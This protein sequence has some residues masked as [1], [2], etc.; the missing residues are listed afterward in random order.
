MIGSFGLYE[1]DLQHNCRVSSI[2]YR[3]SSIEYRASSIEHRVSSIE[4]RVSS[5]VLVACAVQ[6]QINDGV[7]PALVFMRMDLDTSHNGVASTRIISVE[8]SSILYFYQLILLGPDINAYYRC[9]YRA[10]RAVKSMP[11]R[12]YTLSVHHA[13]H[14]APVMQSIVKFLG[15]L[16]TKLKFSCACSI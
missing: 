14:T 11:Y 6:Y 4:H 1:L 5:T 9:Y 2:E 12:V 7:D 16:T 8:T 15:H 3:I 10:Y 13:M